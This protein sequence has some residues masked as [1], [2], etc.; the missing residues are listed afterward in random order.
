MRG[1]DHRL[2]KKTLIYHREL[3]I[4]LMALIRQPPAAKEDDG[5]IARKP[6]ANLH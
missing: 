6:Q 1:H 2:D 3:Y 5:N 4:E